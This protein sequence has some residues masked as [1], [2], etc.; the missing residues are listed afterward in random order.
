MRKMRNLVLTTMATLLALTSI[1]AVLFLV[2]GV[3]D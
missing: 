2:M 3:L 1:I